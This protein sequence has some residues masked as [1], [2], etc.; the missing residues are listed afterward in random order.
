MGKQ[1]RSIHLID[2]QRSEL[3]QVI[4]KRTSPQQMVLRSQ[5]IVMTAQGL[6]VDEIMKRLGTSKLTIRKW[7]KRF[8]DEGLAGLSDKPR[9]GKPIK[10]GSE[11]RHKIAAAAC[12]PPEGQSHWTIRDLALH[13]GVD[14]GLVER[15]FKEQAIKPHLV[16]Y[17]Q[18]STDPEFEE[19]MLNIIGLY[20]NPPDNAVVLSVD[21]K[22]GI[23]ALDRN[24]PVLPLKPHGKLKNIPFEY[25]RLGTTSLLAALDVHQGTVVGTCDKRHTHQ[26]FLSFLKHLEKTYRQRGRDIHI[27]CDNYSTHRHKKVKQWVEAQENLFIHFTP[28]HAS[29][30]NQVEIWLSIMSRK[31]LKQGIFKSIPDLISKIKIFIKNYNETAKPFAWTYTGKPLKVK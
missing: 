2:Q 27:I 19:K 29:W 23:Q 7:K 12:N 14:R 20:L 31:V 5:I 17:Y 25:K 22:T 6:A 21:E 28:T 4:H 30:L 3:E 11:I 24:Q 15:V 16:R 1:I 13:M 26:E 8:I 18:H 10:Y 9:P